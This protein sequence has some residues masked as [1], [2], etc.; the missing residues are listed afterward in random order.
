MS[1]GEELYVS[2]LRE[3]MDNLSSIARASRKEKKVVAILVLSVTPRRGAS[4][5][6]VWM[7]VGIC[8]ALTLK[9]T[10]KLVPLRPPRFRGYL[11]LR[12]LEQG[13]VRAPRGHTER[14]MGRMQSAGNRNASEQFLTRH[15]RRVCAV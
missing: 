5:E 12:S 15:L 9:V 14:D 4:A 8:L 7:T 2:F 11:F 1:Y 6:Q 10:L 3:D 13:V